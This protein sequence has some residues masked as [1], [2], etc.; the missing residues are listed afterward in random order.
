MATRR[1]PEEAP[2]P[3]ST[4]LE[5]WRAAIVARR[6]SS[7]RLEDLVAALEDLGPDI[8]VPTRNAIAKELHDAFFRIL[9]KRVGFDKPNEG[10]DIIHRTIFKLFEEIAT[11]G[12]ADGQAMRNSCYGIVLHRMKDAIFREKRERRIPDDFFQRQAAPSDTEDDPNGETNDNGVTAQMGEGKP[13]EMPTPDCRLADIA[14]P[15]TASMDGKADDKEKP[16]WE[17]PLDAHQVM[18]EQ[19]YVDQLLESAIEDPRKRLA[20]RLH[21]EETPAKTNDEKTL[22]IAEALGVHERTVRGWIKE[23]GELLKTKVSKS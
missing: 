22:S 3:C 13:G 2:P 19:L 21:M 4:D 16:S 12:S 6:L 23:C 15:V 14:I 10:L 8:D 5:G 18:Q 20:F 1:K 17:L 7:F 9:R 11:P